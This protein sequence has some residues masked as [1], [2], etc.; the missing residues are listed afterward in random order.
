MELRKDYGAI[1]K[2]TRESRGIS[3]ETAHEMTKIPMD[4]LRSIEEGYTLRSLSPFYLKGFVKMYA[5]YLGLDVNKVIRDFPAEE[6]IP[7]PM[8]KEKPQFDFGSVLPKKR[9]QRIVQGAAVVIALILVSRIAGCVVS[10]LKSTNR[11][12]AVKTEQKKK[13]VAVKKETKKVT[14]AVKKKTEEVKAPVKTVAKAATPDPKPARSA[15]A[16]A[17]ISTPEPAATAPD[18]KKISLTVRAKKSGWLQ[19]KVDGNL[20]FQ[21]MLNSGVSET[22]SAEDSIELSGK[23]IQNLDFEVNGKIIGDLGRSDRT[24]RRVIVTKDGLTVKN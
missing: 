13:V 21:S 22:W 9:Q 24:T 15:V 10:Q 19:V 23:N 17:V 4:V 5:Q 2:Q 6:K 1:L 3:L 16:P 20:V 8:E 14:T 12:P 11:K 7:P 18:S